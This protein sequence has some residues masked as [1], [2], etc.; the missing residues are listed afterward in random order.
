MYLL[1]QYRNNFDQVSDFH[2]LV[3]GLQI[4]EI[5]SKLFLYWWSRYISP[6]KSFYPFE[7]YSFLRKK[8][9]LLTLFFSK[10]KTLT[11]LICVCIT[12][13]IRRYCV[14]IYGGHFWPPDF[15][16]I[17][18]RSLLYTPKSMV[19]TPIS[20]YSYSNVSVAYM[21]GPPIDCP[22]TVAN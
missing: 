10:K 9:I 20:F 1:H 15:C 12:N 2:I 22:R 4:S 11:L 8:T 13:I 17:S 6:A 7:P 14:I 21:V 3:S 18:V 5:W 19:F 16:L